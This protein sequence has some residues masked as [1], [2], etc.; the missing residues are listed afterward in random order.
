MMRCGIVSGCSTIMIRSVSTG[1]R[2]AGPY[3][4]RPP[5]CCRC[6]GGV[7]EPGIPGS[8]IRELSTAHIACILP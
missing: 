2:V 8:V 4:I 3:Q 5:T 6:R 1:D 7:G